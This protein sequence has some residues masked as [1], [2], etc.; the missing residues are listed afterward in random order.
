MNEQS[1]PLCSIIIRCYNED[2]YIGRLLSGIL[3]QTIKDVEII[4]VDSGSTDATLFIASHF[5]TNIV[6]IFPEDFSFGRALNLGCQKARGKYLVFISAHCWPVYNDWLENLLVP[7][8]D[9]EI[10]LVY[11]KQRGNESS[12]FSENQIFKSWFPDVSN[13]K[14]KHP[15]CNNANCAI[16]KDLW[17]NIKYNEEI[18]G[19]EDLDWGKK[20]LN[21]GYFV[22]YSAEAQIIHVHDETPSKIYNRYRR[23]AI[24]LKQI[25]PEEKFS[26]FDYIRLF[27]IN[28]IS[29]IFHAIRGRSI[30]NEIKGII[31]FRHMQFKGAYDG[32]SL[33]DPVSKTLK[34]TFYYPNNNGNMGS[35]NCPMDE[36]KIDYSQIEG[37][38]ENE[39]NY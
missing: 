21:L 39:R 26:L 9:P 20:A 8:K 15:F 12:K 19:L 13:L 31:T 6:Y 1:R 24:A 22:A 34:R 16:R 35:I 28:T 4:L 37:I 5:P 29:D 38:L 2:K 3:H 32:F 17:E 7:F 10:A 14:Q 27:S 11:G 23:E 30:H 18:T 33:H 25:C 36:K